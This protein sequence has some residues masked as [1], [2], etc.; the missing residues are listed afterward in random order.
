MT[1]KPDEALQTEALGTAGISRLK[2]KTVWIKVQD[3]PPTEILLQ[4][5]GNV[6]DLKEAIRRD[7]FCLKGANADDIIIRKS[8]DKSASI[9]PSESLDDI[10]ELTAV[11]KQDSPFIVSL[12]YE[13]G[14]GESDIK[15]YFA[16][17]LH[18]KMICVL[19]TKC[20]PR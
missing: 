12:S 19:S 17:Y 9:D 7:I 13:Y 4:S 20:S 5:A 2:G 3:D 18:N 11:G 6:D 14:R 1:S 10:V 8:T 16:A 15:F